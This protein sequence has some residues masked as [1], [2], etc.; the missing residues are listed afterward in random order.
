MVKWLISSVRGNRGWEIV[1][2][3]GRAG[4]ESRGIVDLLAIR[5]DHRAGPVARGDLFEMI[6][7]QVK[8]GTARPPTR[9]DI[10][11]LRVVAALY[12]AR[13]VLLAEWTKG[14]KPSFSTLRPLPLD[15]T[16]DPWEEVED[17]D[18]RALFA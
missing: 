15:H 12:R 8:G 4:S 18:V 1:N 16:D 2:F 3:T 14:T 7:I 10:D 6:L 17:E 11:R 13:A 5:K 9:A